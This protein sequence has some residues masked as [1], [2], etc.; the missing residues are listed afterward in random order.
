[1][2]GYTLYDVAS[3]SA[4]GQMNNAN[5]PFSFNLTFST[6][7]NTGGSVFTPDGKTLYGAFNTATFTN[8]PP[9][10][11]ASVLLVAN[12]TN[13]G[14]TLGI[15]LPESIVAK[16]VIT[17]DG[18]NAWSLSASGLIYLP[19]STLYTYPIISSSTSQVFLSE[20][21]CNPGLN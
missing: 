6:R 11:S 19:L 18:A 20:N 2:A 17:P 10:T 8:P 15:K 5:A 4:L 7:Q 3:L 12:P 16:M 21:P 9:P 1:M 13:L 14:I